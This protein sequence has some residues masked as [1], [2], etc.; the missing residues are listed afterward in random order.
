MSARDLSVLLSVIL[1]VAMLIIPLPSWLLSVLIMINIALALLVLLTSMNMSEPLQFSIF[2]SLLLLLTLYRLGLNVSTTRSILSK[3]EAGGVVE[4][5]GT[6]VALNPYLYPDI[7]ERTIKLFQFRLHEMQKQQVA[8]PDTVFQNTNERLEVTFAYLF[9]HPLM[10]RFSG[11]GVINFLFC[12][13]GIC[14]LISTAWRSL[15]NGTGPETSS[16]IILMAITSAGPML[17][18]PLNWDRYFLLPILFTTICIAIGFA[19][20]VHTV[21]RLAATL[22]ATRPLNA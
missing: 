21:R 1:I 6:F 7:L 19:W 13:V 3:G 14:H 16:V 12:V 15:W 8:L 22:F 18:T 4:T 11:A 17:L 9:Q 2:P 10:I 5:F 20:S